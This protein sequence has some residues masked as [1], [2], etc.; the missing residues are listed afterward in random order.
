VREALWLQKL[1]AVFGV[2][3]VPLE[4]QCD[5]Q[6]AL[7]L[8]QHVVAS[9]RSKHIDVQFHFVRDRVAAGDVVFR[10]IE[11]ENNIA[12]CLTKAVS[13]DLH[14]GG[15]QYM[16]LSVPLLGAPE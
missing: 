13:A 2:Q 16:G 1:L 9:Q 12:D 5:S 11:S 10:Y 4:I 8:M 14:E 3:A 6:G 15:A 7:S